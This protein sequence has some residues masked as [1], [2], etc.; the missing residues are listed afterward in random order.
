MG[1]DK[2]ELITN[3][4]ASIVILGIVNLYVIFPKLVVLTVVGVNYIVVVKLFVK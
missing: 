3:S 1:G 4:P 2:F